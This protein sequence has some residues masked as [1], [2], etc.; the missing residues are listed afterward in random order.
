MNNEDN[1]QT[2]EDKKEPQKKEPQKKEPQIEEPQKKELTTNAQEKITKKKCRGRPF[3]IIFFILIGSFMGSDIY[4][5]QTLQQTKADLSKAE[6]RVRQQSG[7]A[8]KNMVAIQQ[9]EQ[10]QKEQS[11]VLAS[12]YK[13]GNNEDWAIAEVE[14]L[15]I[16]AMHRLLLEKDVTMALVTLEAADLRLKDLK[17]PNLL[18]VRQQLS[19]DLNQLRAVHQADITGMAIYLT[20]LIKLSVDLPFKSAVLMRAD[21]EISKNGDQADA[22]PVWKKIPRLLWEEI[23]SLFVIQRTGE[24]QQVLLLPREEYFLIQN[25][26]LKLE[27]ARLSVLRGDSGNLYASIA[28]IQSWLHQYF[29]TN[30]AAVINVMEALEKMQGIEL[31]PVLPDI[32]SSMESLRAYLRYVA[33]P[34]ADE[35]TK[36]EDPSIA[37]SMETKTK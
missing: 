31:Q 22:N 36:I 13:Q 4:L 9:L 23:K 25:L 28:I 30:D 16:I 35:A 5:W 11:E 8:S 18:P 17:D 37:P 6:N 21:T 32:S 14:H 7:L 27:S 3:A 34:E 10:T 26:Q 2:S 20:D 33:D 1:I 24:T 19:K 29:N 15:F 12:L